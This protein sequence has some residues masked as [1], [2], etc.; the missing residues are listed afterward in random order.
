MRA[1]PLCLLFSALTVL[2]AAAQ[3]Q[4][5][6]A[7]EPD[8]A[9]YQSPYTFAPAVTDP[10][11]TPDFLLPPKR[12]QDFQDWSR[13][14]YADW[15]N[16][17][18]IRRLR[19]TWGPYYREFDAP[20][21][22]LQQPV[23]W[24][25]LRVLAAANQLRG[26]IPYAHHHMHVWNVPDEPRWHEFSPGIGVDCSDFTY[27]AYDYGLGIL[28][29]TGIEEQ[30]AITHAP[31]HMADGSTVTIPAQRIADI[32]NGFPH[33]FQQLVSTLQPGDLLFIRSD[34]ALTNKISHVIIWLGQYASDTNHKDTYFVMDSHGDV[35]VDSNGNKIPSGPQIRP[36]REKSYYFS[37]YDHALRFFPLQPSGQ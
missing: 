14:P 20:A 22:V 25:E 2:P 37:S 33:D 11:L 28:L 34:P 31:M 21:G 27:W 1:L 12:P 6:A 8:R 18:A 36:F 4:P 32:Q 13:T 30:A 9:S 7:P 26:T 15:Y 10:A 5:A 24:D 19:T 23:T 16:L 17:E 29:P 35:V 3:N